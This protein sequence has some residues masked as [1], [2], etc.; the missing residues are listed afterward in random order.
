MFFELFPVR[1]LEVTTQCIHVID[2]NVISEIEYRASRAWPAK[3][4]LNYGGWV[5]RAS[6]GVTRR[7]NSVL[8]LRDV[9]DGNLE[10]ALKQVRKFYLQFGLPIRFQMTEAS[11]PANLDTTLEN[12]G[13][14]IDMEVYVQTAIITDITFDE[15]A[16]EVTIDVTP[17]K[18]WFRSYAQANGY[19]DHSVRIRRNIMAQ[20]EPEKVFAWI[21]KGDQVVGVGFS[22]LDSGWQ[23]LFALSI[24]EKYRRQGYAKAI[25]KALMD[26]G[27]SQGA[28]HTYLQVSEHNEPALQLYSKLGFIETYRYWYRI[29]P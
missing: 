8:P 14:T 4:R 24:V 18:N 7:G 27:K 19:D 11:Q 2:P 23:G 13:F 6:E 20:V 3:Y 9:L 5:L 10:G 28:T 21:T 15:P 12:L 25:T 16:A 22:V 26:W 17:C 1:F 29:E